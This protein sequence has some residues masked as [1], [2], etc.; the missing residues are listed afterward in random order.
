MM[1][2]FKGMKL[3][4][5]V[6][7]IRRVLKNLRKAKKL[8]QQ[9]FSAICGKPKEH[10]YWGKKERGEVV[11]TLEDFLH[12]LDYCE[13]DIVTLLK[14]KSE[15]PD[16]ITWDALY[17]DLKELDLLDDKIDELEHSVKRQR[18][19]LPEYDRSSAS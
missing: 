18:S 4:T 6:D 12:F 15:D 5:E 11:I 16:K 8:N 19:K 14:D 7:D 9:N 10:T 1:A 3:K 2:I 13:I 17:R